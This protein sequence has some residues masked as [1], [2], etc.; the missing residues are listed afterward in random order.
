M[1]PIHV[2][3]TNVNFG[4]SVAFSL[5]E[6]KQGTRNTISETVELFTFCPVKAFIIHVRAINILLDVTRQLCLNK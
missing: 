6:E 5:T 1:L 4:N 3:T 2:Y